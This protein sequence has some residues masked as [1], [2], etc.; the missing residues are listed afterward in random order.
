MNTK[1]EMLNHQ[2]FTTEPEGYTYNRTRTDTT[3]FSMYVFR[4]L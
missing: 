1:T 4:K 2:H 3:K